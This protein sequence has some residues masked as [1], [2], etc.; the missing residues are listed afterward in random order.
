MG[1]AVAAVCGMVLLGF[2]VFQPEE[3]DTWEE[4]KMKED[5]GQ[6]LTSGNTP[7]AVK[8]QVEVNPSPKLTASMDESIPTCTMQHRVEYMRNYCKHINRTTRYG[9][10]TDFLVDD[11]H[12]VISCANQKSGITTWKR[13]MVYGAMG[14]AVLNGKVTQPSFLRQ[15]G[16]RPLTTYWRPRSSLEEKFDYH[17]V[18]TVRHPLARLVSAYNDKF[19]DGVEAHVRGAAN[20]IIKGYRQENTTSS[21]RYFKTPRWKEFAR[22]VTDEKYH[23]DLATVHWMTFNYLCEPCTIKYDRVVKTETI[24]KDM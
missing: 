9:Y 3:I 12:K 6:V 21:D 24:E 15:N 20:A 11:K 2:I 1:I 22:Y 23:T 4:P 14:K 19:Y 8:E 7:N 17:K 16:V 5:C 10:L 13:I 18:I